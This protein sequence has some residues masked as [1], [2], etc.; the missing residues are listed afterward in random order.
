MNPAHPEHEAGS[1]G[2]ALA[3]PLSA[4]PSLCQCLGSKWVP[5]QHCCP[6]FVSLGDQQI[7]I[8][9]FLVLVPSG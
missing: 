5:A 9:S 4:L 1:E 3:V 6:R 2:F 8:K 7:A